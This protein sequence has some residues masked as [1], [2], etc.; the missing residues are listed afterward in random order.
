MRPIVS[1]EFTAPCLVS[2][3]KHKVQVFDSVI[4]HFGERMACFFFWRPKPRFS[5]DMPESFNTEQA[6]VLYLQQVDGLS[7]VH[8]LQHLHLRR[9]SSRDKVQQVL[10]EEQNE[11]MYK[12]AL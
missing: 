4:G 2:V 6:A 9:H 7:D 11:K 3:M 1:L 10:E 12:T 8:T 5:D